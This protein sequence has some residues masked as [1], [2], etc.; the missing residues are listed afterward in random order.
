[1]SDPVLG[2]LRG[3]TEDHKKKFWV[4]L[5]QISRVRKEEHYRRHRGD[6]NNLK[7]YSKEE[8]N[9]R[10][11]DMYSNSQNFGYG[12]KYLVELVQNGTENMKIRTKAAWKAE[13]RRMHTPL[14]LTD[15]G[16][17]SYRL[18]ILYALGDT[19]KQDDKHAKKLFLAASNIGNAKAQCALGEMYE[20]G[21]GGPRDPWRASLWYAKAAEK[22]HP[23]A[24]YR[25]GILLENGGGA[26]GIRS[27]P[28]DRHMALEYY[29]IAAEADLADA[30]FNCGVLSA[31]LNGDHQT[32]LRCYRRAAFDHNHP[33]AINNLAC[34]F[35]VG[36]C[37]PKD[38]TRA[39]ELYKLAADLGDDY[40]QTNMA[41]LHAQSAKRKEKAAQWFHKLVEIPTHASLLKQQLMVQHTS[42]LANPS[43]GW[44]TRKVQ[45]N[46]LR[47]NR[48]EGAKKLAEAQ[49]NVASMY[50]R[51]HK[52]HNKSAEWFHKAAL[53][54]NVTAMFNYAMM[55]QEGL[56][57]EQDIDEARYWLELA[58]S[59][60]D[61]D[62]RYNLGMLNAGIY[63]NTCHLPIPSPIQDRP[64]SRPG[65]RHDPE[66]NAQISSIGLD[67]HPPSHAGVNVLR[68]NTS[69]TMVD[70][71]RPGT[72]KGS[73]G[74]SVLPLS[75][76]KKKKERSPPQGVYVHYWDRTNSQK[77][78]QTKTLRPKT[79]EKPTTISTR[80][81]LGE[82]GR[83]IVGG[84]IFGFQKSGGKSK[85]DE[86][87]LKL[88]N[89]S[90]SM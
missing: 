69:Y 2:F 1:M 83:Q 6:V 24:C 45:N 70:T 31:S 50:A 81:R 86:E 75:P 72:T 49:F 90:L 16:D 54:G 80:T 66:K 15:T 22:R 29:T 84:G 12:Q 89:R 79:N 38:R 20:D 59:S 11:V 3:K 73:L 85:H 67:A 60:G 10:T 51:A 52:Q 25:L 5:M 61:I 47:K 13:L 78:K 46:N 65:S 28:K 26:M 21:R 74:V 77:L 76:V 44:L 30:L 32:A 68:P 63:N 53:Q 36:Q 19:V 82:G 57:V 8:Q 56:G 41:L 9:L 55:R 42:S 27:V 33:A 35:E 18:G 17:P 71:V 40:A 64:G 48:I 7:K 34:M 23:I 58:A 39:V 62:A 88:V 43:S 87:K 14:K 37:V 4:S